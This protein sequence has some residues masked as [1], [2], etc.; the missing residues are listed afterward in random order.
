MTKKAFVVILILG[1]VVT[2][3][4]AI[5]NDLI[6]G[7]LVGGK[8][9]IPFTFASGSSTNASILTLDIIFWF[10]VI[11]GIWKILQKTSKK[12]K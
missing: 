7:S 9:G 2:Y 3:G 5:V 1:I 10:V 4:T 6:G 11:W 8:G 12:K